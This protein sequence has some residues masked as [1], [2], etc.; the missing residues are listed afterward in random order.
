MGV[1]PKVMNV[2]E[3]QTHARQYCNAECLTTIPSTLSHHSENGVAGHRQVSM[4]QYE[5][6]AD[7]YKSVQ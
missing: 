4:L 5:K 7:G 2:V 1:V 3:L 6:M